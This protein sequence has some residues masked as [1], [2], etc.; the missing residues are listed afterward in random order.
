MSYTIEEKLFFVK[1]L[2]EKSQ[3]YIAKT[4]GIPEKNLRRWREQE[5]KLLLAKFKKNAR[6]IIE[7]KK[8]GIEPVTKEIEAKLLLFIKH[9]RNLEICIGTNEIIIR[10]YELMPSLKELT[11][12]SI[13]NWCYRF[14]QRNE[15]N[16]RAVTHI[17]QTIKNNSSEAMANFILYC[18]DAIKKLNIKIPEDLNAIG[19]MDE[20]PV[21][22][23]MY[24]NKTI[25]KIGA[26]KV[27]IK[28]FG[29]DKL[30]I[31]IILTI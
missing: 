11:Y 18:K 20:T 1:L 13:H 28:S 10:A 29:C 14:L 16:L 5:S 2:Q 21:F 9:A 26:K 6:R 8:P 23:E 30:R 4:Y 24:Q 7:E 17:G 25:A 15:L 27:N 3:K 22:F 19:N 31:S 12:K